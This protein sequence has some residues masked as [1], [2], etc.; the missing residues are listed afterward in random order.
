MSASE[1]QALLARWTAW[2]KG[3]VIGG[4]LLSLF[5]VLLGFQHHYGISEPLLKRAEMAAVGD[6]R[7]RELLQTSTSL[8]RELIEKVNERDRMYVELLHKLR[9]VSERQYVYVFFMGVML[10]GAGLQLK[11]QLNKLKHL[12]EMNGER[13][14]GQ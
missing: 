10:V 12:R 11:Q 14:T 9:G 3:W 6:R 13:V 7:E 8:E 5:A 4:V 1:K 2:S